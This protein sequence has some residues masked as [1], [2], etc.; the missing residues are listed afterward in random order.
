MANYGSITSNPRVGEI[1]DRLADWVQK[2]RE[3]DRLLYGYLDSRNPEFLEWDFH[4]ERISHKDTHQG[5]P[6]DFSESRVGYTVCS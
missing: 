3:V 5:N 4:L 2:R 1:F 6:H